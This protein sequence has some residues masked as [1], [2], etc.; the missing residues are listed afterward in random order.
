MAC[1]SPLKKVMRKENKEGDG[2]E[3]TRTGREA[4][5]KACGGARGPQGRSAGSPWVSEK[6]MLEE[7]FS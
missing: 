2:R 1:S 5:A 6:G 3:G 7:L 4:Q